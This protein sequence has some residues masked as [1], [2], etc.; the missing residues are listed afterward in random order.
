[1]V[2]INQQFSL[3]FTLTLEADNRAA[4]GVQDE[5]DLMT[6]TGSCLTAATTLV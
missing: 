1:M 5:A 6:A 2:W 3:A 4:R